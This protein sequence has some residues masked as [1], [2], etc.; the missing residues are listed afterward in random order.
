MKCY[1]PTICNNKNWIYLFLDLHSRNTDF[2]ERIFIVPKTLKKL[3]LEITELVE[4]ASVAEEDDIVPDLN[5]DLVKLWLRNRSANE[6]RAGWYF[7]QFIKMGLAAIVKDRAYAVWDI[8]TL[9]LNFVSLKDQDRYLYI[10]KREN[11]RPYF[12]TISILTAGGVCRNDPNT[13]FVAEA[14]VFDVAIMRSLLRIMANSRVQGN[15]VFEKVIN[16]ISVKEISK[17]GFSEFESYGNYVTTYFPGFYR[18]ANLRTLRTGSY[19]IPK[20]PS[21]SVLQW[22][23]R[24][25]DIVTIEDRSRFNLHFIFKSR[26]AMNLISA[27]SAAIVANLLMSSKLR[28]TGHKPMNYDWL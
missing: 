20:E 25:F 1:I 18:P 10:R 11:H 17:S 12:D 21:T 5:L 7:Q 3:Y 26:F 15:S 2:S 22:A 9:P 14:M 23:G 8:D 28:L 27:R 19:I 24:S 6:Q 16:A 4:R 13:S